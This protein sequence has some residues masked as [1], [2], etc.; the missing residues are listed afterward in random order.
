[1]QVRAWIVT[2]LFLVFFA[3]ALV[4]C[5]PSRPETIPV[6][7]TVTF[8][9]KPV[10]GASVDFIPQER[11]RPAKAITDAAGNFKIQTFAPGDGAMPGKYAITIVKMPEMSPAAGDPDNEGLMGEIVIAPPPQAAEG[12][13]PARYADPNASGLEIEVVEGLGPVTLELT[14]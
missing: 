7:G 9:G 11:Q 2:P 1:M 12:G 13:I 6:S 3:A 4:G 10:E 8:D 5:G 14:P